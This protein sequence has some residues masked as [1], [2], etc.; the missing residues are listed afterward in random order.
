MGRRAN[1][2]QFPRRRH[3][4]SPRLANPGGQSVAG[5]NI[6]PTGHVV[7]LTRENVEREQPHW[8]FP[9][10]PV[11]ETHVVTARVQLLD[12]RPHGPAI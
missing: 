12:F 6:G 10:V 1:S 7:A 9:A 5:L 8:C 11:P 3:L 2:S 4:N